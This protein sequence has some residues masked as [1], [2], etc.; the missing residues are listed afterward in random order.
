MD[1]LKKYPEARAFQDLRKKWSKV[2]NRRCKLEEQLAATLAK[3]R[4]MFETVQTAKAQLPEEV[5][6]ALC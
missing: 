5:K 3:E 1:V 2:Y 6:A 4:R